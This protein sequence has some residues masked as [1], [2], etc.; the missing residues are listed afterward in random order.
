MAVLD[1]PTGVVEMLGDGLRDARQDI[2]DF[3]TFVMGMEDR[4]NERF[5]GI[6]VRFAAVIDELKSLS[7]RIHDNAVAEAEINRELLDL[8]RSMSTPRES[9]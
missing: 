1:A 2:Q 6:D 5:E 9:E 3:K 4:I 7:Q 8:V